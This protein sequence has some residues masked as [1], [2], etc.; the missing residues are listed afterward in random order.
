MNPLP[1]WRDMTTED[2]SADTSDWIAVL[3]IAAIEQHGPHLPLATDAVIAEGM[4]ARVVSALPRGLPAT[5]LPVQE[6][7][8]SNEHLDFPGTLTVGWDTAI[9]TWLEIGASIARGGLRKLVI[10]TSHGGNVNPMGIAARE[11]RVEHGLMVV[12]TAWGA[13]AETADLYPAEEASYGIHG[14][15]AETSM[16]LALRPDLVRMER[17]ED[18]RTAQLDLAARHQHLRAHGPAGIGWMAQDLHPAGVAGDAT[19]ASAAAGEAQLTRHAEAFLALLTEIHA[20]DPTTLLR[21]GPLG[22]LPSL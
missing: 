15:A 2:F 14:G 8:K 1:R 9:R 19:Q 4:V 17:T 12:A 16:M 13:T 20:T 10:V 3:P 21:P 5:F 22:D 18:F 7:C 11:L 6:V